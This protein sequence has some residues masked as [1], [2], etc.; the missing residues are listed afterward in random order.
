[1]LLVT[2]MPSFE[3]RIPP[4]EQP[5]TTEMLGGKEVRYWVGFVGAAEWSADEA[6]VG[7]FVHGKIGQDR[8]FFF[9][10]KGKEIYQRYLYSVVEAD[11]LDELPRDLVSTDRTSINWEDPEALLL[12][13]WGKKKVTEW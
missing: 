9:G 11:W 1:M 3:L 10:A 7:V 13:D 4:P 5:Y 2:P 12:R 6:G 8:P